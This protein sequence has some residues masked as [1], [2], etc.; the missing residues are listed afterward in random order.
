MYY[1]LQFPLHLGVSAALVQFQIMCASELVA[2]YSTLHF[3]VGAAHV[4]C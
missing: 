4:P 1:I 3:S 2:T